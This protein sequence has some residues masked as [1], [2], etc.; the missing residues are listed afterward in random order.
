[1]F[2][3]LRAFLY[4]TILRWYEFNPNKKGNDVIIGY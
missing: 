4:K 1:M 2:T 3:L